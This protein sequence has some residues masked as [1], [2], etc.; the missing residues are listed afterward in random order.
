M[1]K[2][3]ELASRQRD[4]LT[5]AKGLS[6]AL[7]KRRK[8]FN[9]LCPLMG[10]DEDERKAVLRQVAEVNDEIASHCRAMSAIEVH[11]EPLGL[12]ALLPDGDDLQRCAIALM[13]MARL[14]PTAGRE[15]DTVGRLAE[16]VGA[17]DPADALAV[18]D[19]FRSTGCLRPHV[20]CSR[21]ANIDEWD[22]ALTE[23]AF[24]RLLG[25]QPDEE[26]VMMSRLSKDDWKRF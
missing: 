12:R 9:D 18:R 2:K 8:H 26:A 1:G 4:W 22:V 11:G 15:V 19:A 20:H 10:A 5:R 3:D 24:E 16:I 13:V 25:R 23:E 14:S 21:H 17:C 7:L 6:L